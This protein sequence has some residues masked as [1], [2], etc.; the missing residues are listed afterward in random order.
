MFE[1]GQK[2]VCVDDKF[3]DWYKKLYSQF[4]TKDCVY[5]VRDIRIGV[6]YSEG[7]KT[8]AV[9]VL[10]IGVV[11]PKAD[12]KAGL[13]RGFNSDRFRPLDELKDRLRRVTIEHGDGTLTEE[14][15]VFKPKIYVETWTTIGA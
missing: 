10:L 6:M 5:V 13:E 1:I 15:E 2:V 12:S 11:N 3:A 9:S 7:K 14:V 4:P 8:G